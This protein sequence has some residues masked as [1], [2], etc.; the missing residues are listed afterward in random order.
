MD[1]DNWERECKGCGK[2]FLMPSK[3]QWAYKI[4]RR[5][6][7]T[8]LFCSWSCLQKFRRRKMRNVIGRRF[9]ENVQRNKDNSLEMV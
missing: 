9:N 3:S 6:G 5:E 1:W 8:D 4:R 7:V 2:I